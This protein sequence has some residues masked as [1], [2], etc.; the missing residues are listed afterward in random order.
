MTLKPARLICVFQLKKLLDLHFKISS[1]FEGQNR[2]GNVFVPFDKM[3]GLP[4]HANDLRQIFLGQIVHGS[5]DFHL[6][7]HLPAASSR[8]VSS[9]RNKRYR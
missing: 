3:D 9:I 1:K 2:R 4:G 6:I 8:I 7:L 5:L